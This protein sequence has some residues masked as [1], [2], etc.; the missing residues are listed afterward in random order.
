MMTASE[1]RSPH[2]ADRQSDQSPSAKKP[3]GNIQKPTKPQE[4]GISESE[5]MQGDNK[6]GQAQ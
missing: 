4:N 5:S 6:N 2:K 1:G 3:Q